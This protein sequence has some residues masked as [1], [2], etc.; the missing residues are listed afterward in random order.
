MKRECLRVHATCKEVCSPIQWCG[1]THEM[2]QFVGC[3]LAVFLCDCLSNTCSQPGVDLQIEGE[4]GNK[5][6]D[7]L[8][9]TLPHHT[10]RYT[11]THTLTHTHTDTHTHTHSYTH[12]YTH[13]HTHSHTHVYT[14]THTHTRTHTHIHIHTHTHTHTHMHTHTSFP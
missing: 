8:L 6:K 4:S 5:W 9:A 1:V 14:H 10:H 3:V 11:H 7:S 13:T 12:R 2:M